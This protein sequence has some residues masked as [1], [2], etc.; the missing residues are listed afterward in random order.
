MIKFGLIFDFFYD[1][2]IHVRLRPFRP[3]PGGGGYPPPGA[4]SF[5]RQPKKVS[6]TKRVQIL[7]FLGVPPGNRRKFRNF[8]RF[9]YFPSLSR[10]SSFRSFWDPKTVVLD[11]QNGQF[12]PP[13]RPFWTPKTIISTP[14]KRYF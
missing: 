6:I 1:L 9:T 14:P 7:G 12:G 5:F 4:N 3:P 11:P 13:K 2:S 10:K 8:Q